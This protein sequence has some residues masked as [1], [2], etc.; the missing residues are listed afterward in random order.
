MYR[1]LAGSGGQGTLLEFQEAVRRPGYRPGRLKA[2]LV[3]LQPLIKRDF[4]GHAFMVCS[5]LNLPEVILAGWTIGAVLTL[6]FVAGERN[7]LLPR[8][9]AAGPEGG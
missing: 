6:A 7:T 3:A 4:Y 5:V 9:R 2:G 1:S 8:R